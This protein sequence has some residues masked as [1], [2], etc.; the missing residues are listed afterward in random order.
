M[1][2]RV[3]NTKGAPGQR[4][5]KRDK[6]RLRRSPSKRPLSP[7]QMENLVQRVMLR[8]GRCVATDHDDAMCDGPTD[9]AHIVS[10]QTLRRHYEPGH[11]IFSDDRNVIALCRSHHGLFDRGFL[12]LPEEVFPAGFHPFLDEFGIEAI[13]DAAKARRV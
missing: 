1:S 10:Q 5:E 12:D 3:N 11:P 4:P 2:Y 8:D 13:W 9:A 6:Q 7:K